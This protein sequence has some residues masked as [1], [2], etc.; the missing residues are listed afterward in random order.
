M[1]QLKKI[2]G[3]FDLFLRYRGRNFEI[4]GGVNCTKFSPSRVDQSQIFFIH[5]KHSANMH[6]TFLINCGAI[7][8][9]FG[10]S[11]GSNFWNFCWKFVTSFICIFD[12]LPTNRFSY[13]FVRRRALSSS[14]Q[15]WDKISNLTTGFWDKGGEK[16]LGPPYYLPQFWMYGTQTFPVVRHYRAP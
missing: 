4:L 11:R 8:P 2:W 1:Q 5:W 14:F 6:K 15:L 9:R 7:R 16:F 3:S 13:K 12:K 10:V